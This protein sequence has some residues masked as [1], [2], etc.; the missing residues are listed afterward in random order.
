MTR[1]SRDVSC[2]ET[3]RH[4]CR[5]AEIAERVALLRSGSYVPPSDW[6]EKIRIAGEARALGARLR[7][8]KPTNFRPHR[9]PGDRRTPQPRSSL[10]RS[11]LR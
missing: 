9:C 8:E 1:S 10:H 2:L 3:L 4:D 11:P 6:R 7:A 5:V